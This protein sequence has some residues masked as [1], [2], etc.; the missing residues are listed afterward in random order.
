MALRNP[1]PNHNHAAEY[2]VSGIPFVT[3]SASSEL[4]SE[5]DTIKIELPSVSR[6]IVVQCT[7]SVGAKGQASLK[8]G[9]SHLGVTS[10]ASGSAL[11]YFSV[12]DGSTT[13]RLEVKCK[14]IYFAKDGD[15]N[16]GFQL[17]AGLTGVESKYFP[18]LTG[19]VDGVENPLMAGV[20]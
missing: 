18:T 2:Q 7:G 8:F 1:V 5:T 12:P 16:A 11:R 14:E 17:M 9:F 13:G 20:G 19:S 10:A 6:W 4:T 15:T 3:G